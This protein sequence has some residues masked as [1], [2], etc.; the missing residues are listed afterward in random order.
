MSFIE[1]YSML[2]SENIDRDILYSLIC[3]KIAD[4]K[5]LKL[6][7]KILD[8]TKDYDVIY[9]KSLP[10]GNYSSQMFA[11]IY[12]NELDKY[13]KETLRLKFVYRYM[14]DVVIILESKVKAKEVLRLIGIFLGEI[15]GLS[16]NSKTNIFKISQGVNFCGYKINVNSMKLINRGKKKVVKKIKYIRYMIENGKTDIS[17]A[18]RLLTG[19][20]GYMQI[21]DVGGIVKKYF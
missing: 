7:R 2:K 18:K 5:V 17:S 8:S 4:K 21:A 12:L 13:L 15:L 16:L 20:L 14:D 6:T 9:G 19:H 10:I 1:I 11:N 3:K